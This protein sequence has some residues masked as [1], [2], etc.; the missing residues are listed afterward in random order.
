[1]GRSTAMSI[2]CHMG[3]RHAVLKPRV[4]SSGTGYQKNISLC[5]F[6]AEH[7]LFRGLMEKIQIMRNSIVVKTRNLS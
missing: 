7:L 5:V 3:K 4:D 2:H 6:R 1:M